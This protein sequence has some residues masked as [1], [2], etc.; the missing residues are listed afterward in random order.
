[1]DSLST[2]LQTGETST[3]AATSSEPVVSHE[4]ES[5]LSS[6]RPYRRIEDSDSVFS[7]STL[8]SRVGRWSLYTA[9][10]NDSVFSLPITL[11]ELSGTT[12][13]EMEI[14]PVLLPITVDKLY[15]KE[16]Y[17]DAGQRLKKPRWNPKPNYTF[18]PD[19]EQGLASKVFSCLN[20]N[21]AACK[22][23]TMP[24]GDTAFTLAA[25]NQHLLTLE[26]LLLYGASYDDSTPSHLY[27]LNL[28]MIRSPHKTRAITNDATSCSDILY[29]LI[30]KGSLTL[31]S[32]IL[33]NTSESN[34]E[35]WPPSTRV[36][37][38]SLLKFTDRLEEFRSIWEPA[39]YPRL[40][41]RSLHFSAVACDES[42][43]EDV[44]VESHTMI[45]RGGL[46]A[47]RNALA[48][49]GGEGKCII[50]MAFVK[51]VESLNAITEM[52]YMTKPGNIEIV[53]LIFGA[54]ANSPIIKVQ[55]TP[56]LADW[57]ICYCGFDF[58][59]PRAW[60]PTEGWGQIEWEHVVNEDPMP[61]PQ[62][63][64][65]SSNIDAT[66]RIGRTALHIAIKGGKVHTVKSLINNGADVNASDRDG[67][68]PLMLAAQSLK[69]PIDIAC[70]L[71]NNGA[72][73]HARDNTKWTALHYAARDGNILLIWELCMRGA[74]RYAKTFDGYTPEELAYN[75]LI[76]RL[77]KRWPEKTL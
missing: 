46:E 49:A 57:P 9:G 77:I 51:A 15:N 65:H 75:G 33:A 54:D 34:L 13:A 18:L 41:S 12:L 72:D 39:T 36:S 42:V 20:M 70:H 8:Q 16:R 26:L 31:I 3:S 48:P 67:I 74:D 64:N 58:V 63:L 43:M 2:D 27:V 52:D 61:L 24:N 32:M 53:A 17:P 73:I 22:N 47:I 38:P 76:A 68:T 35:V 5:S 62:E 4:F 21:K 19:A 55:G 44:F 56:Q 6:S 66:N 30:P 69:F 71:L 50:S 40:I 37:N 23:D 60:P 25:K 11:R 14:A 7:L 28:P 29:K 10:S 59:S 45:N 1:M